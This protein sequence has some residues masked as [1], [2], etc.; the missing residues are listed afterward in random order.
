L[1]AKQLITEGFPTLHCTDTGQKAK[2]IMETL[3]VSHLPL[4]RDNEY[5]GLVSEKDIDDFD[6]KKCCISEKQLILNKP[7]VSSTEHIYEVIQ[8]ISEVNVSVMPVLELNME[9]CG[10]IL[11]SALSDQFVELVSVPEPGAIIVL[12]LNQNDYFLSQIAQIIESNGA[13]ILSLYSKNHPDSVVMDVTLKINITDIT[14]IIQTFVRYDYS[15]KAVYM[16]DSLLTHMYNERF[17]HF[18]KYIN[19]G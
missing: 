4:V 8:K 12:E 13:K 10:S 11:K 16:D 6:L 15:I 9:Y 17:D 1:I 2:H 5:L 18:L 19:L 7:F 3:K 14:S